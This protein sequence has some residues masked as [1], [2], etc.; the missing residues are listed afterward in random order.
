MARFRNL[1]GTKG[2]I[3]IHNVIG[4]CLS[5]PATVLYHQQRTR[6]LRELLVLRRNAVLPDGETFVENIAA[7]TEV[8]ILNHRRRWVALSSRPSARWA[9]PRTDRFFPG[10][11]HFEMLPF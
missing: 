8:F 11:Q 1:T 6:K 9:S 7:D 2:T 5:V 4:S 3:E 10:E